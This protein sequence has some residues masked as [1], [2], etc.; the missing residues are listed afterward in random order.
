MENQEKTAE[1]LNDLIE[2]NN[3]RADGFDKASS[4]LSDENI[5]LKATFDKLSSDSR[6]NSIELAGLV[7]RSGEEP[8]S[9]NTVLGTLHRAWIDIKASF[10]GN[11]RHSILAECER[12]EDAIKKAYRDALQENELDENVRSVLLKQQEGVNISHDA[13]KALR[14]A[15]K[16]V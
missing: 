3:D 6:Q 2:I 5:D 12:G 15:H 8:D 9:G 14:D 11:D 16:A 7:G 13:I 4:D 10:G 1:V